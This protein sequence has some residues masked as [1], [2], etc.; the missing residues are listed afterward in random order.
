MQL[1]KEQQIGN[2]LNKLNTYMFDLTLVE[3]R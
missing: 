1:Q 2:K 3:L